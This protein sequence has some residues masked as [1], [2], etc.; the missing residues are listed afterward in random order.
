MPG[1]YALADK[2]QALFACEVL[3]NHA[4][5]VTKLSFL[6]QFRRIFKDT[7]TRSVCI[8]FF[9]FLSVWGVVQEFL[10]GFAC[11]PIGNIIPDHE[12]HCIETLVVWYLTSV[13]NIITD[14][15]IFL[16]PMPAI[17]QLQLPRK[18]KI[19]VGAI[20]CLGFFTCIISIVRLCFL[21]AA[22]NTQDPTWD[23]V[24]VSFWSVVELNCGIV[25]ASAAT[26]RPLLRKIIPGLRSASEAYR[27][28]F[29]QMSSNKA[30]TSITHETPDL[31]AIPDLASGSTDAGGQR[32]SGLTPLASVGGDSNFSKEGQSEMGLP[33]QSNEEGDQR[34]RRLR[35]LLRPAAMMSVDEELLRAEKAEAEA[36]DDD[37]VGV[38]PKAAAVVGLWSN[39]N[40]RVGGSNVPKEH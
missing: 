27:Y 17:K 19:V 23:N 4:Q 21:R 15:I 33:L 32:P 29:D 24:P 34:R 7:V 6:L 30:T 38:K 12:T 13:V 35:D 39:A 31:Y 40:P 37:V 25:C 26:L 8:F 9:G 11:T 28:N 10:V 1:G 18:Q 16:T 14:F 3:Y 2:A 20:F 36:Q 5:I 22:I